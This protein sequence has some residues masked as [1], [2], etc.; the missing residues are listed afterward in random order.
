MAEVLKDSSISVVNFAE[1]VS[2]YAHKGMSRKEIDDMLMPLPMEIANADLEVSWMAAMWRPD[3]K[4]L[5]LSL[6]ERYCLAFA[7]RKNCEVWTVDQKWS[8]IDD[9]I[10]VK[11][12]VIR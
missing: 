2:F 9:V 4:H 1:V 8:Q 10:K 12:R 11:I 3:T 7:K 6:R 5:G